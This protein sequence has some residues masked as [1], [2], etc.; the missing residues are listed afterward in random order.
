MKQQHGFW[1][2][3][4]GR[5]TT[6]L[7]VLLATVLTGILLSTP[8]AAAPDDDASGT[9]VL[10]MPVREHKAEQGI[11]TPIPIQ[12]E[13]PA[14]LTAQRVLVSYRLHGLQ[15]WTTLEL[16]RRDARS[17]I[18]A[19]PCLE[20]STV[21]GDV[22]YYIRVH[23]FDGAVV[24][25]SGSRHE[26]Y[27]IRIIHD[28]LRPDLVSS[29]RCPDPADCPAGLP[30]CPSERVGRIPC[31]SDDDCEG[32]QSCGWDGYCE[33]VVRPENW[34]SVELEQGVGIVNATGAC[35]IASQENEGYA[36][37][38]QGDGQNYL[39][40]PVYTNEALAVGPAH[41]RLLIG[42]E[43]MVFYDTSLTLRIGYALWGTGPTLPGAAELFPLSA[44]LRATHYWGRDPLAHG[45]LRGYAFITGGVGSFDTK[46][47]VQVREDTDHLAPQGGNDLEQNLDVWKRAGDAS[48]G[49]GAGASFALSP[50]W[51]IAAELQ[52]A[53]AFPYGATLLLPRAGIKAG[54]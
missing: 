27:R 43:R 20:V 2:A 7:A 31:Q 9:R 23:N 15:E 24:A 34:L 42:Y 35:S 1:G 32:A 22:L 18:G 28:S 47:Q 4:L 52:I 14:G 13:L 29:K 16:N 40:N 30:G 50:H 39:G 8:C 5:V 45:G 37:F 3:A 12:I 53:Q 44:E 36:C 21:T 17:F 25:Y 26:P 51:A 54:F 33:T 11:L 46:V 38:R 19:I 6:T 41:A 10:H 49:L 48:L